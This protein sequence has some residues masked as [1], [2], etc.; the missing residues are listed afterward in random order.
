[1]NKV[2]SVYAIFDDGD[3]ESW[4]LIGKFTSKSEAKSQKNKWSKFFEI[5]KDIFDQPT[6][7]VAENDQW[8]SKSYNYDDFY[9]EDSKDYST[10]LENHGYIL[11]FKKIYIDESPLDKE[12]FKDNMPWPE[13]DNLVKV[14]DRDWKLKQLTK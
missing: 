4:I 7:W 9:W 1:M 6:D 10:L 8:Y 2:W 14:W 5:H 11:H 12:I 13:F 3:S